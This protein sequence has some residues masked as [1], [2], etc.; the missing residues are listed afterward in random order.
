THFHPAFS[1]EI[2]DV[3]L[4]LERFLDPEYPVE[5]CF[6]LLNQLTQEFDR[7]TAALD[8]QRFVVAYKFLTKGICRGRRE[9]GIVSFYKNIDIVAIRNSLKAQ[10][11]LDVV[12][13]VLV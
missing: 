5:F 2:E 9:T 11:V 4:R 8:L 12:V 7:F 1:F 6:L 13:I 10:I 3:I